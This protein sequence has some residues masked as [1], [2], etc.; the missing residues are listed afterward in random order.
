[1]NRIFFA[2]NQNNG[3]ILT[4]QDD[5]DDVAK[6]YYENNIPKKQKKKT[7]IHQ[8]QVPFLLQ[9]SIQRTLAKSI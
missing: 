6:Y 8:K 3:K 7:S 4:I 5:D 9:T 2:E 1:M